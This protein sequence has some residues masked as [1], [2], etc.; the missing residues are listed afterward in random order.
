MEKKVM[1]E[2]DAELEGE[3]DFKIYDGREYHWK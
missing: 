3:E 2:I 1:K